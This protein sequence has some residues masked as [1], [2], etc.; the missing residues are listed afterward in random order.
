MAAG[1]VLANAFSDRSFT[2][3]LVELLLT[4]R[5]NGKNN[6]KGYSIFERGSKPK[7]D[8]SVL[9]IIEES[10]WLTNLMPSG[11]PISVTDQ[12]IMEMMHFLVVNEACRVLDEGVVVRPSYLD[13]ASV[14]GMS[15]PSFHVGIV[16]WADAVGPNQIYTSLKKWSKLYGNFFEPSRFLKE[17]VTRGIPLCAFFTISNIK[18]TLVSRGFTSTL[19]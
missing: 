3:P 19:T 14:L 4:N 10:R 13:T 1:K 11:K 15:F 16:F 12:E 18:V 17:R 8:P 2:S 5:R 7:P 9:P 6:G